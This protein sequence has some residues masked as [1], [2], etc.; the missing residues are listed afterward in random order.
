MMSR[1]RGQAETPVFLSGSLF[2]ERGVERV[3][4]C[5]GK[6][7]GGCIRGIWPPHSAAPSSAPSTAWWT[8]PWWGSTKARRARPP[9]RWWRLSGISFTA[10][11]SSQASAARC[12]FPQ[13][14][15]AAPGERKA[16]RSILPP[17]FWALWSWP[18]CA[19]AWWDSLTRPSS[20]S[21]GRRTHCCL[22]R[23]SICCR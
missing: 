17:L 12:S 11:A 22:W 7:W 23:G 20:G 5:C 3:W 15:E 1:I 19:G 14:E 18:P 2:C 9:W 6:R 4:T 16:R 13:P 10:W 8:W 21:S